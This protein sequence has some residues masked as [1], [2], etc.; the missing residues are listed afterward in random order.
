MSGVGY[1]GPEGSFTHQ[2]AVGWAG[3]H[4][5]AAPLVARGTVGDVFAAVA[6][7]GDARGVVAIENT[8]EG[9]VVPSL[10][11]IVGSPDVV[12]VDEVVLDIEFDAFVRHDHGRLTE[13]S[14][15]PHGLAQC[16]GFV[17]RT[18]L[19]AVPAASNAAACRD[20]GPHQ[21]ALGPRICGELYDLATYERGVEDFAG[22]RTRF[23]VLATRAAAPAV[24]ARARE[25]HDGAWRTMLAVTPVV[26]GPGVLARITRSFGER[27]VNLSSLVTRPLK[28]VHRVAGAYVFVLTVDAAPWEPSVRAVLEDL[29]RAGDSLKTLGVVPARGELDE[30]VHADVDAAHVPVGS[31]GPATPPAALAS[32][33]LW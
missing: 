33:L 5:G 1:L 31:V 2:A 19:R 13:V 3:R 23:L 11:A 18:G 7:G 26:T 10:D 28:R 22:A 6:D 12:A 24:L 20:A 30:G 21:V 32:G 29:L 9:Y 14:A 8:V 16:Q 4:G 15:H 17:G 25:T 27:G